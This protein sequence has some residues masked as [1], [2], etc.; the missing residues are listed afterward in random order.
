MC[1]LQLFAMTAANGPALHSST[2]YSY[3]NSLP[4]QTVGDNVLP[5]FTGTS[6]EVS[7]L[8]NR[9]PLVMFQSCTFDR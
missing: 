3:I 9:T 1:N 6:C 4:T 7:C 5:C 8:I 2:W